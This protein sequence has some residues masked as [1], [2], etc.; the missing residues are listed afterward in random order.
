MV[1]SLIHKRNLVLEELNM[2]LM[3]K[4]ILICV[5]FLL[6]TPIAFSQNIES[7]HYSGETHWDPQSKTM[8]F[9][10]SGSMPDDMEDFFWRVGSEINKIVIN[11][12]VTINGGF[13]VLYRQNDNPL[14][15]EGKDRETSVIFG[16]EEQKWTANRIVAENKKWMYGSVSVIEDATVHIKNLTSKNPRGY[17]ISGH[18]NQAIIHLSEC[19]IID[20]RPGS[21]N[22]SDGFAGSDG[23][24]VYNCFF[25]TSDDAIKLYSDIKLESVTIHQHRNGAPLQLG[26]GGSHNTSNAMIKNVTIIGVDKE[27]RYNMAPISWV[28]G[29]NN[30]KNI[31]IDGIKIHFSGEMYDNK[32]QQW[33]PAGI[34]KIEPN[35][36]ELNLQIT[37]A[38]IQSNSYGIVNTKGKIDICGTTHPNHIYECIDE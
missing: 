15:I 29:T 16:T 8:T 7:L 1:D 27:H 23:S 36:C 32:S 14:T 38:E 10:T 37:N 24:S 21:N 34:F 12:D 17:H 26:W 33:I 22:N 11:K 25:S 20:S 35:T 13:R 6:I 28:D 31:S 9:L 19:N 18:A 4:C 2:P 5:T 3:T 30:T